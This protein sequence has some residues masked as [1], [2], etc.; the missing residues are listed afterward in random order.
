MKRAL[1]LSLMA[2]AV[3]GGC[4]DLVGVED[5]KYAGDAADDRS[6]QA[7]RAVDSATDVSDVRSDATFPDVSQEGGDPALADASDA[8]D[9][10]LDASDA[11]PDVRDDAQQDGA[12][13]EP[14][15]GI[16]VWQLED[17]SEEGFE[18]LWVDIIPSEDTALRL[19][20]SFTFMFAFLPDNTPSGLNAYMSLRHN[21]D[22]FDAGIVQR[23]AALWVP[24]KSMTRPEPVLG[25][26]IEQPDFPG[27]AANCYP[28]GEVR[29]IPCAGPHVVDGG[30]NHLVAEI[31]FDWRPGRTYRY[32]VTK[33]SADAEA[34]TW[35]DSRITDMENGASTRLA[36]ILIHP[37]Y[38]NL[39][40]LSATA[41]ALYPTCEAPPVMQ[42]FS[43]RGS[44]NGV[45]SAAQV[46]RSRATCD[47]PYAA[48]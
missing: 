38:G 37:D 33:T 12:S 41:V 48:P 8:G 10:S 16:V 30:L 15:D 11:G 6:A 34:G 14:R 1:V 4:E 25:V 47:D 7:D 23:T 27:S 24:R 31:P 21:A 46:L 19:G 5:L 29:P 45:V 2:A 44:R 26:A 35:W 18:T 40:S 36:R 39:S 17:D 43:A 9:T 28:E 13:S 32:S 3:I 22:P 42:A 20:T